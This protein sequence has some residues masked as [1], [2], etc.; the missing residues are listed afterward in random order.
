M[1][2][3]DLVIYYSQKGSEVNS[4]FRTFS[5]L[6]FIELMQGLIVS[7]LTSISQAPQLPVKHPVGISIPALSAITNQSSPSEAHVFLLFGQKMSTFDFFKLKTMKY[8]DVCQI[9]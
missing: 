6:V 5:F 1:K 2:E 3:E 7:P 9:H 8:L 4:T